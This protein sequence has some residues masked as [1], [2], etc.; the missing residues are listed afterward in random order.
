MF[1]QKLKTLMAVLAFGLTSLGFAL[2]D[3]P[4]PSLPAVLPTPI[5]PP[6]FSS[7][8]G[9]QP[10]T[11]SPTGP[12]PLLNPHVELREPQVVI[13]FLCVEMPAGFYEESGLTID[14]TPPK[15]GEKSPTSTAILSNRE[16]KMLKALIRIYPDGSTLSRPMVSVREG[17]TGYMQV[18]TLYPYITDTDTRKIA[19]AQHGVSCRIT[20]K[21][22]KDGRSVTLAVE[23][24][25]GW[26]VEAQ[27]KVPGTPVG[28]Q[29]SS[30]KTQIEIVRPGKGAEELV[31]IHS[32][33]SAS[34]VVPA[35]GMAVIGPS[36]SAAK[37]EKKT[38]L[39]F[40][41]TPQIVRPEK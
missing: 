21:I 24:Q 15:A 11:E 26:L 36:I 38:E 16:A 2:A 20:P 9:P 14:L 35:G 6:P 37:G 5:N 23:P 4:K 7:Q 32:S 13:D 19:Y 8:P 31:F 39:L 29:D 12:A 33:L 18:G 1:A 22:G 30:A 34:V 10:V 3:D 40:L 28:F 41:L 27:I 17:E 25:V